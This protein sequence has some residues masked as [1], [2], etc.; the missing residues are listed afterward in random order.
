LARAPAEAQAEGAGVGSGGFASGAD[1]VMGPKVLVSAAVAA[2]AV[3]LLTIGAQAQ[4]CAPPVPLHFEITGKIV[5]SEPGFTQGLEFRDGRLYESTGRIGGTGGSPS[6]P[7]QPAAE[8]DSGCGCST[9]GQARGGSS[10][11][12]GLLIAAFAVLRG[13][14]RVGSLATRR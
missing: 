9:P 5:R 12:I 1:T 3:A 14:R 10:W 13:K 8:E 4:S 2:L 11:A 7:A 6:L